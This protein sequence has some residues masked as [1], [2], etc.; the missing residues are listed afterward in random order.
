MLRSCLFCLFALL[1]TALFIIGLLGRFPEVLSGL[2]WFGMGV[3]FAGG[4]GLSPVG[5]VMGLVGVTLALRA[6]PFTISTN[7]D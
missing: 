5:V 1:D 4:H 7:L 2:L 6:C 3:S